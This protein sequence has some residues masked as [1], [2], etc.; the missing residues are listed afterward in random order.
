MDQFKDP[1]PVPNISV[2]MRSCSHRLLS[3][4]AFDLTHG[5]HFRHQC[6]STGVLINI[7]SWYIKASVL[8]HL[9]LASSA[10]H[11]CNQ[12]NPRSGDIKCGIR[13]RSALFA[14]NSAV[15]NNNTKRNQK[16]LKKNGF[17]KFARIDESTKSVNG[18]ISSRN[19]QKSSSAENKQFTYINILKCMLFFLKSCLYFYNESHSY[20]KGVKKV[21][22]AIYHRICKHVRQILAEHSAL[23]A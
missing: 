19:S 20:I 8:N 22:S 17:A 7:I 2:R 9:C 1:S 6:K 13:P 3:W 15:K 10:S 14:L 11:L 18:L 5:K 12:C 21:C 4:K 23:S 16:P